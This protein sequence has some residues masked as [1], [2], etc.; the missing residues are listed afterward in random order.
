MAEWL[1]GTLLLALL[2]PWTASAEDQG[3]QE[4]ESQDAQ[5]T[6]TAEKTVEPEAQKVPYRGTSVSYRNGMSALT[7]NQNADMTYNPVYVMSLGLQP[8]WWFGDIFNVGLSLNVSR[9]L[10]D[11]DYT[12]Y[13]NE[14]L[15]D[16]LN[17]KFSASKFYTIP[18]LEIN[19]GASLG[20]A[21]PTSKISQ[22]RTLV[23]GLKPGLSVGRNFELLKGLGINYG[24]G[25][26][27]NFFQSNVPLAEEPR[28]A[29]AT[30]ERYLNLGGTRN[31]LWGLTHM[32]SLGL[33]VTDWL[34]LGAN[35]G[36]AISY[37]AS[38]K[39]SCI[40]IPGM[41]GCVEPSDLPDATSEER[42]RYTM[43]Y[44]AEI[45]AKPWAPLGI[46]LGFET[47]NPQLNTRANYEAPIVNRY[48]ALFLD[49]RLDVAGLVSQ[50][51][52]SEE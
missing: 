47:A 36:V 20:I 40:E 35:V 14:T 31:P 8:R 2:V 24:F 4:G 6:V 1:A 52:G 43:I 27:R 30:A 48:T 45:E 26:T 25:V 33:G 3:G 41:E 11:S 12:T 46:A 19:L 17:I 5:A 34:S 23:L 32:L 13:S 38:L 15:V 7:L 10:T 44:G 18:V 9:E 42:K 39:D 16:D 29:G 50:L 37:A 21:T 28:I 22:A 51:K 49:V